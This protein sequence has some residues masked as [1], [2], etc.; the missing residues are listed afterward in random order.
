MELLDFRPER[1]GLGEDPGARRGHAVGEGVDVH[2]KL[3]VHAGDDRQIVTGA[4][5]GPHLGLLEQNAVHVDGDRDRSSSPGVGR[6]ATPMTVEL[7]ATVSAAAQ[8]A[9]SSLV[10]DAGMIDGNPSAG[11]RIVLAA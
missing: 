3:A 9:S 10:G 7:H 1:L 2:G 4:G 5:D 11:H 8:T 6:T